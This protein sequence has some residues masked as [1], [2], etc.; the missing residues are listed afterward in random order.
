MGIER[1]ASER[2]RKKIHLRVNPPGQAATILDISLHGL[3]IESS[4]HYEPNTAV[5]LKLML[6]G[7]IEFQCDADVIWVNPKTTTAPIYRVAL[8]FTNLSEADLA[9]LKKV[10]QEERV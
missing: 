6:P 9:A 4:K 2:V 8:Q 3:L 5:R 10:L 1:R 7:G